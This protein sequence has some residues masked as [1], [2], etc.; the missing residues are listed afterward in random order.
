MAPD[1][2]VLY[3]LVKFTPGIWMATLDI[4]EVVWA[5]VPTAGAGAGTVGVGGGAGAGAPEV[6]GAGGVDIRVGGWVGAMGM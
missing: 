1:W 5:V 2:V 6:A 4:E 3:G